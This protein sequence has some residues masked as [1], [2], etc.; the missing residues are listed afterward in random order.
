MNSR[1]RF[2]SAAALL[3]CGVVLALPSQASLL[4]TQ[5]GYT[6]PGLD[7][8][9]YAT[10]SY[11][12]TFGPKPIPGGI[13]FTSTVKFGNS[14]LGSVLGQGGYGLG[15]N[16]SFGGAAVYA[17]LDSAADYMSF[18]FSAAVS[19]F[20][21]FLNYGP[22]FGADP[23]IG[24]YDSGG[25][26]IEQWNLATDAPISTPGGFNAFAFRGISLGSATMTEF[27]LS[28]SYILAA[29]TANGAPV[30]PN[31]TPEPASLA[32]V[33]IALAGVGLARRR[34]AKAV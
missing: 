8:T 23:M 26:L 3:A 20:G 24:A 30:D 28:N 25:N 19:S 2:I 12:F 13:T 11:N 4:T 9:A 33:A 15:A 34:G 6:G 10:N 31:R 14:G 29:A 18:N 7:L 5:A 17:G 32:L 21:A 22:G 27:R 16:G 1:L